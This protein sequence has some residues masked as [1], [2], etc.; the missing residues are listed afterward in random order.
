MKRIMRVKNWLLLTHVCVVMTSQIQYINVKPTKNKLLDVTPHDVMTHSSLVKC[1]STCR[2]TPWCA[3][4]NLSPDRSTCQLLSEEV[5]DVRSLQSAEGWSYLCEYENMMMVTPDCF[6]N[7][8]SNATWRMLSSLSISCEWHLL[9]WLFSRCRWLL[10]PGV[11]M[12]EWRSSTGH[13]QVVWVSVYS[14][15]HW[16]TLRNRFA[17]EAISDLRTTKEVAANFLMIIDCV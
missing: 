15:I 17:V 16:R 10:A 11:D 7:R 1:F 13:G 4:S 8:F 3:S 14:W 2:L 12:W 6:A 5:S 9:W